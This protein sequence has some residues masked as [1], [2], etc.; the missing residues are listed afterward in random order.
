MA[1]PLCASLEL[2][3]LE[4]TG[5]GTSTR[6]QPQIVKTALKAHA[7][8]PASFKTAAFSALRP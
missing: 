3:L 4:K 7:S 2:T 1:L 6:A 5:E 8:F